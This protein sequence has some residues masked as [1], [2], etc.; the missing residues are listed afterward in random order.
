MIAGWIII[1][2]VA[3]VAFFLI[4]KSQNFLFFSSI[5]WRY[6][7]VAIAIGV[8]LFFVF[9]FY[10]TYQANDSNLKSISGVVDFAGHYFAWLG[11]VFDKV[12]DITGY[13]IKQ[14]WFNSTGNET[15]K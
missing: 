10:N 13:A 8:I 1:G 7:L 2:L 9:S 5:I 3:L 4:F 14:D 11:S 12:G 15:V 6:F